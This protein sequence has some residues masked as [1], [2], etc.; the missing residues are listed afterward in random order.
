MSADTVDKGVADSNRVREDVSTFLSCL[1]LSSQATTDSYTLPKA[2]LHKSW[3]LINWFG[4][5]S[6]I[7]MD[8]KNM[9]V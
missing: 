5:K 4:V 7:V 3:M 6:G 1:A 9:Q 8:A 2:D